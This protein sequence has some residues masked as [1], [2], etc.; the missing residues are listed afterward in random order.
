MDTVSVHRHLL[1]ISA[2]KRLQ[3]LNLHYSETRQTSVELVALQ[4][5]PGHICIHTEH[6]LSDLISVLPL[7]VFGAFALLLT[8]ELNC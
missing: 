8:L 1:L 4:C 6:T 7:C 5:C 3:T 2:D